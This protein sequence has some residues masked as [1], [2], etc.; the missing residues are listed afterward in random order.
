[1]KFS[2]QEEYGLR[3]LVRIGHSFESGRGMTI[4]EIS[5]LESIPEHSVAKILRPLRIN[6]Y[7]ESERGH[8][9]GYTLSKSP[10]KIKLSDVLNDLGGKLY[11]SKFCEIITVKKGLCNNTIDCSVRS[12]WQLIQEAVDE[13]VEKYTLADLIKVR[14]M[15]IMFINLINILHL[16]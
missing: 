14:S 8:T 1:M 16:K 7:L 6:G 9:G 2:T 3:L 11:D 4:P 10:D 13:V 5:K 15:L 12:V